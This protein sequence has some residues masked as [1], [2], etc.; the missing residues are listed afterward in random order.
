MGLSTRSWIPHQDAGDFMTMMGG[1]CKSLGLGGC[2]AKEILVKAKMTMRKM[3][4]QIVRSAAALHA[5]AVLTPN[6]D[7]KQ[8]RLGCTIRG[9]YR[10]NGTGKISSNLVDTIRSL[11]PSNLWVSD[12]IFQDGLSF[13][14]F[15]QCLGGG[16][17]GGPTRSVY[18]PN[19]LF[20]MLPWCLPL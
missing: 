11:L 5:T 8:R 17:Y 3:M 18:I 9:R 4:T 20:S 12:A 6:K 15:L 1:C 10:Q 14:S 7:R 16:V 19:I 2:P 13:H